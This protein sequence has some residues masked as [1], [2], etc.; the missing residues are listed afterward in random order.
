LL[1]GAAITSAKERLRPISFGIL[2][3]FLTLLPTSLIPLSEVMNDHRVFL[4]YIGLILSVSWSAYLIVDY[5][6]S[7]TAFRYCGAVSA[8]IIAVLLTASVYGTHQRNK[9]WKTEETL[10]RDVTE[11]NPSNGRGL[12]NYG[13]TLMAKGDY[14]HAEKYF[15]QALNLNPQYATLHINLG[16]LNEATGNQVQAEQYF[17]KA[18]SLQPNYP[19]GYFYYA[20]FLNKQRRF[21]EAIEHLNKTL[22]IA[23]AHM[24][25]RYLLITS[26]QDIADFNKAAEIARQTLRIA[27]HDQQALLLLAAIDS[28]T[29]N[30][31]VLASA[32]TPEH[33][34]N[35]S[36]SHYR[37]GEFA[38]CIA[39][40]Q[41]A[42]QLRPDDERA[43]NNICAAYNELG[44]W[45]NAIE[46]GRRAVSLN[47]ANT[48]ARNNLAWAHGRK[49]VTARSS[50]IYQE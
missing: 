35:L 37:A 47:P 17:K 45:E 21:E 38:Q 43:Y 40:A 42:L 1:A 26:Y 16:V 32:K 25:A 6:R 11:K 36:L 14:A 15:L 39:A 8:V 20:R 41:K 31:G 7:H 18:I 19:E 22:S 34:I 30:P 23:P 49:I 46:A 2:W 29:S 5:C 4:P 28:G 13:L 27:P 24:N 9:V 3:Y 48:L 12:M 10:W 50:G 33:Y 44:Q